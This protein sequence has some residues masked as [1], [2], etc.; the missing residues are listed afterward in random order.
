MHVAPVALQRRALRVARRPVQS[1]RP[2][3]S[4]QQKLARMAVVG[5]IRCGGPI[6]SSVGKFA[7]HR[8]EGTCG[9][10]QGLTCESQYCVA[11]GYAWAAWLI[12]GH[13]S[14]AIAAAGLGLEA[15]GCSTCS[16]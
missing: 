4:L 2:V 14:E 11:A 9:A 13:R 3:D 7:F 6:R 12:A 8:P 1:H 5:Q 10:L 16:S 15:P